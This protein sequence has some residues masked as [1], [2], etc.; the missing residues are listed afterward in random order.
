VTGADKLA[1]IAHLRG[2]PVL[3]ELL[4]VKS[5]P[6]QMRLLRSARLNPESELTNVLIVQ[7]TEFFELGAHSHRA[8]RFGRSA[9][10]PLGDPRPAR[11]VRRRSKCRSLKK[12][13]RE[14]SN[15]KPS[16]P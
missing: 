3:P 16:D 13:T 6:S 11:E 7:I 14:D 9:A 5:L 15:L 4:E 2:D 8:A 10:A 12:C 1:R